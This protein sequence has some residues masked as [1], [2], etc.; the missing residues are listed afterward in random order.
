MALFGISVKKKKK[1][2]KQ[3]SIKIPDPTPSMVHKYRILF[4]LM[5]Q[6]M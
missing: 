3:T 2:V 6:I 4:L 1:K 5:C